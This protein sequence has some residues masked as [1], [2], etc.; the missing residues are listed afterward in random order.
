VDWP[1]IPSCGAVG[2]GVNLH[3]GK[4][5]YLFCDGHVETLSP[6]ETVRNNAAGQASLAPYS[7]GAATYSWTVRPDSF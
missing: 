1:F 7:Y 5:N 3:E 6:K 2:S 4:F